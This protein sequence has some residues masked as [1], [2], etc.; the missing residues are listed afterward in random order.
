[1]TPRSGPKSPIWAVN[2]ALHTRVPIATH[3]L[4]LIALANFADDEDLAWPK[5][6]TLAEL[7]SASPR[8]VHRAL[9]ALESQGLISRSMGLTRGGKGGLRRTNSVYRMLLPETVTRRKTPGGL[10]AL[11]RRGAGGNRYDVGVTTI[12]PPSET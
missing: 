11:V 12:L 2:W 8:T 9:D 1:M 10:P 7:V 6:E 5:V 4:V 3:K